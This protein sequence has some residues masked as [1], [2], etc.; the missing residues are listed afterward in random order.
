MQESNNNFSNES[1]R[2]DLRGSGEE[3]EL[4]S[5]L[6]NDVENRHSIGA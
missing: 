4:L 6:F 2:L 5:L 3:S 1:T